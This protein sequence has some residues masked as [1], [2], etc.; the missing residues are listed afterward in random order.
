[1]MKRMSMDFSILEGILKIVLTL[2]LLADSK[3][4]GNEWTR[5]PIEYITVN[6]RMIVVTPLSILIL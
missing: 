3:Y 1:M 2:C 6:V 4:A 5:N